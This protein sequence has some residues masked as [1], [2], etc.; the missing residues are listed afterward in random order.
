MGIFDRFRSLLDGKLNVDQQYELLRSAVSGTMSSF[1]MAKDKRTGEVVGLKI[2]DTEKTTFFESRFKGLSKPTEGEIAQQLDHP[3]IVKTLGYGHTTRGETYLL[4]EYL[5]GPGLNVLIKEHSPKLNGNRIALITQM[6]E[7]LGA[8]HK[9]GFIHRDICPRNFICSADATELKLI[10]FGLT[11]PATK[12]FMQPGNR[13]G[14][15]NYM[16][17]EV[18]RRRPTDQRLDIF[19]LGA[20]CY[21]LCTFELPWPSQDT[22]GKA[23]MLHDSKQPVDILTVRPDLN[24]KLARLI[25]DCLATQPEKRP[26]S[27]DDFLRVLSSVQHEFGPK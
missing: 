14:T 7:A 27:T 2:L 23:A 18:V 10:D 9:A 17:P 5:D 8:V 4:M 12:E 6:A 22:T 11:V 3:R 16:A 1:Y 26:R 25:M 20:T 15:P 24:P 19:S 13:T 21:Q